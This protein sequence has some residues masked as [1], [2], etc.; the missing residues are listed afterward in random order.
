MKTADMN[1]NIKYALRDSGISNE[2]KSLES[3][4]WIV[5]EESDGKI[6]GA[7][8]IGGSFHVS[9]IQ[10]SD[11]FQGKGLGRLLQSEVIDE[12]KRR[13]YSFITVF[14][15]PRNIPSEKLHNSFGYKTVFRVHYS[16]EIVNDVKIL[17]FRSQGKI[18]EKFLGIFNTRLGTFLLACLLK[19]TKSL[20]PKVILYSEDTIPDPSIRSM[21]NNFEKI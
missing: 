21:V 16:P 20:F 7:A 4:D 3:C 2:M 15:D 19:V 1:E 18:V 11:E 10:I 17:V 9:G 12:A 8:G 13:K 14:N 6:V 5:Y